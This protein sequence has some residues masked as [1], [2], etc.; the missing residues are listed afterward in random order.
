MAQVYTYGSPYIGNA[1]FTA[2]FDRRISDCWHIV[3]EPVPKTGKFVC[4]FRKP[5]HRVII[6]QAGEMA[7]SPNPLEI[8]LQVTCRGGIVCAGP[9]SN[10]MS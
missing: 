1:A 8:R 5:G 3:H 7:V 9:C 6:N 10:H 2:D 4:L